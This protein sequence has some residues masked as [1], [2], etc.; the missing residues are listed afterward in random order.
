MKDVLAKYSRLSNEDYD[1]KHQLIDE[2]Q[3]LSHQRLLIQD[4]I[5]DRADLS[6]MIAVE[7][8]DDG[9]T[10]TNFNRPQFQQLLAAAHRGEIQ[11]I[12]VKDFSRLGRNFLEVS[13]Y[14]D[15][16]FPGLGIRVISIGDQFDSIK[17][18][19]TTAGMS[20]ALKNL[21]YEC[22]SKDLSTKVRTAQMMHI[23]KGKYVTAPIYGYQ[24]APDDKHQL[25]PDPETAPIV[26]EIYERVLAGQSTSEIA[27]E[28]NR[29]GIPTPLLHKQTRI[30]SSCQGH[31]L[32]WTRQTIIRLVQNPKY[33]GTMINHMKES[34]FIRDPVQRKTDKSEWFVR[35]NAHEALV[36]KEDFERA[37][38]YLRH[39]AGYARR[40]TD[41]HN[42]VFICGYCGYKLQKSAG[43]K[44]FFYCDTP[45][46]QEDSLCQGMRWRKSDLEA[47]LLSS[48]RAQLQLLGE[49]AITEKRTPN[50]AAA[51][52]VDKLARI[53]EALA[54]C[55]NEKL[56]LYEA[57][58]SGEIDREA[59]RQEKQA[60]TQR[61]DDL[62]AEHDAAAKQ[63][64][65][66]RA[67]AE[68]ITEI[69]GSIQQQ[70]A[71]S[72]LPDELLL[73]FMYQSLDKVIVKHEQLEIHWGFEDIFKHYQWFPASETT[74]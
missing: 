2:S 38:Q 18:P 23:Q 25:V 39:P 61:R 63:Y 12:I 24:K 11:C 72:E 20:V 31:D 46:Y 22:Y 33:T 68:K 42:A 5:R 74:A 65:A 58:R 52:Q 45:S 57:Y 21:I 59:Y 69:E 19:G 6:D 41:P 43:S 36:S 16:I 26:K 7:Y 55:E 56:T 28:L 27:K 32:Q 35:E 70:L 67:E 8:S 9:Y 60:I 34:R 51:A 29:R 3:S 44:P 40:A 64:A 4:F 50:D 71:A 10:G 15:R 48:Y 14:I 37:N 30:R 13:D 47:V 66:Q 49:L 62:D 17:N 53:E 1:K 54:A 73:D